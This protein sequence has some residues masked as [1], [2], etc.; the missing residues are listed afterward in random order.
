MKGLSS[1]E[2]RA[3]CCKLKDE[4]FT[5]SD[6]GPFMEEFFKRAWAFMS[7]P[8]LLKRMNTKLLFGGVGISSQAIELLVR[9]GFLSITFAD[10]DVI[11]IQNNLRQN[12]TTSQAG[13]S[14]TKMLKTRLMDINSY[15]KFNDVPYYLEEKSL[16]SLLPLVD[17]FVNSID[18]DSSAFIH[19]HNLCKKLNVKEIFPFIL[20]RRAVV[21]VLDENSPTFLEYFKENEPEPLKMK[22]I[23]FC[24][25]NIISSVDDIQKEE[26]LNSLSLYK[27]YRPFFESDPQFPTGVYNYSSLAEEVISNIIDGKDVKSFPDIYFR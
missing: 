3:I 25:E 17:I 13:K 9:S 10:G 22:I 8:Q 23:E 16:N 11:E 2:L 21:I 18:F 20:G 14:K 26:L 24:I 4:R 7:R 1:D 15:G 27:N 12:F 19:S 6:L 5:D